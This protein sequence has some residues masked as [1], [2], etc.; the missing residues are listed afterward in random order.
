MDIQ[1]R[2]N[3]IVNFFEKELGTPGIEEIVLDEK[4]FDIIMNNT[5][6]SPRG[7]WLNPKEE[8]DRPPL[9]RMTINVLGNPIVI[10]RSKKR[11]E[12]KKPPL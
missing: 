6:T 2:L 7:L 3:R 5:L 4:L 10:R 9:Q 1:E 11:A 8:S 12:A